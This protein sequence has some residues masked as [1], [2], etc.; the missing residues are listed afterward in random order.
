MLRVHAILHLVLRKLLEVV[1][2]IVCL[3]FLLD[4]GNENRRLLGSRVLILLLLILLLGHLRRVRLLLG[5]WLERRRVSWK[6]LL[7]LLVLLRLRL[8]VKLIAAHKVLLLIEVVMLVKLRVLLHVWRS[9]SLY[10]TELLSLDV[11]RAESALLLDLVWGL[12]KALV[13]H[14]RIH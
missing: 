8:L 6:T 1:G 14:L 10:L 3:S 9:E 2:N 11:Q 4:L 5:V 7:R 13:S 12:T